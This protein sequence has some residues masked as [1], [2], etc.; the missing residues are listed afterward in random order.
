[1]KPKGFCAKGNKGVQ[2]YHSRTLI[3]CIFFILFCLNMSAFFRSSSRSTQASSSSSSSNPSSL[4]EEIN[5]T[6]LS[7]SLDNW[8][9]PK[10]PFK[11]IYKSN[12]WSFS[13][14]YSVK[15]VEQTIPLSLEYD[16]IKLLSKRSIEIFKQKYN[17][18]HFGLVQIAAKPLSREGLDTS[19][20]LY[21][22]DA[23]FL[24]FN[25]SLLGMVET[26][27]CGG[28]VY[29]DYFPN[30][31]VS[32]SNPNILDSLT[33]NVKI[34]NYKTKTGSLPVAII[35]RLQYKAMNSAFNSGALRTQ[36][37]GETILFKLIR[38]DLTYLFLS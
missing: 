21:L 22:R 30:F 25:D 10:H 17:Y 14:D 7:Q 12:K 28:P 33:L 37:K 15:T 13:T 8:K 4:K 9:I 1:M 38:A 26:S 35:F 20:L 16:E 6:D 19:V 34:S 18:L 36:K 5:F 11:D 27:L 24:D 32:L 3:F 31:S 29:F 2:S 23:R